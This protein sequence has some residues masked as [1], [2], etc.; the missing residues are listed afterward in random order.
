MLLRL[1]LSALV[2]KYSKRNEATVGEKRGVRREA[3]GIG[4][5]LGGGSMHA[6]NDGRRR[7]EW[8]TFTIRAQCQENLL[9]TLGKKSL[10]QDVLNFSESC[11]CSSTPSVDTVTTA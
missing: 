1:S 2:L 11:S 4:E 5:K 7:Q 8:D 9:C 3:A 6:S 10:Y